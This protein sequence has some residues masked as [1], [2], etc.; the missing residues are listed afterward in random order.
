MQ[1]RKFTK[2]NRRVMICLLTIMM[3]HWLESIYGLEY[4]NTS[5]MIGKTSQEIQL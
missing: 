2:R 5:W 3:G 4:Y 1:P